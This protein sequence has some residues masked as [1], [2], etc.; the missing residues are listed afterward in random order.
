MARIVC[1]GMFDEIDNLRII[2]HHWGAYA[3]HAEGRFTPSWESRNAVM[4]DDEGFASKLK[5]PLIDYFKKDFFGD[6]AMFGAQAASQAGFDFFGADH[7]LF[8][9]DAPYDHEGGAYNIRSTLK[10]LANLRCT[11]EER[12]MILEDNARRLFNI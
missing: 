2:A 3:P 12:K 7:S 1:S 4:G 10:V 9:T 5:K 11:N 8:A 6:T